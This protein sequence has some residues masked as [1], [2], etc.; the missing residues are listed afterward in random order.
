MEEQVQPFH[1]I[2]P[3]AVTLDPLVRVYVADGRLLGLRI[4]HQFSSPDSNAVQQRILACDKLVAA[5]GEDVEDAALFALSQ[6]DLVRLTLDYRRSLH[7][8][9]SP[10]SIRIED[11]FG[12]TTKLLLLPQT[13]AP[14]IAACL[15]QFFPETAIVGSPRPHTSV[16]RTPLSPRSAFLQAV[17]LT[18]FFSLCTAYLGWFAMQGP[19]NL[20]VL[21]TMPPNFW[22]IVCCFRLAMKA[23]SQIRNN[24]DDQ[25][26]A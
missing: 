2:L 10:A 3:R 5:G 19:G 20:L 1:A 6:K 22:A 12:T 11:S 13:D 8:P 18:S 24:P 17:L 16:A 25:D 21:V 4:G 23:R 15:R 7:L 9:G 26:T 14:P